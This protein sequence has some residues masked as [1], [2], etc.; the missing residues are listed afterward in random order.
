VKKATNIIEVYEVCKKTSPL[1]G[2]NQDY[3][4]YSYKKS[5][6]KLV[7]SFE[8]KTIKDLFI[9]GEG[10]SGKTSYQ[11]MIKFYLE[12]SSKIISID[13]GDYGD[14]YAESLAK[15]KDFDLSSILLLCIANKLLEIWP[16]KI[17]EKEVNPII[18]LKK[19]TYFQ[20]KL[21]N[22]IINDSNI[23]IF[24]DSI[25][26][27]INIKNDLSIL[28]KLVNLKMINANFIINLPLISKP[29]I[30]NTQFD[31]IELN[32]TKNDLEEIIYTRIDSNIIT[33]RALDLAI[34]YCNKNINKLIS[35][36]FEASIIALEN[37]TS[38]IE[39]YEVQRVINPLKEKIKKDNIQISKNKYINSIQIKDYFSI[40]NTKLENLEDK[41]EIYFVGENGDGKTIVLQ[42]LAL[43]FKNNSNLTILADKYIDNIKDDYVLNILEEDSYIN[44][45][46]FAYGINRNKIDADNKDKSGYSG[47]FDTPSLQN[48]TFLNRPQELFLLNN[49]ITD[50]FINKIENLLENKIQIA[51]I[52]SQIFFYESNKQIEF[53]MLSEGYKSTIIWLSDLVFRLIEKQPKITKL[54]DFKAVVLVDE[55]DL[56][57]HPKWKYSFVYKLRK[58]FPKIQF[59]MTTHSM[60]TILGASKDAVFYN[61]YKDKEGHTQLSEQFDDISDYS[62]NILITSRLFNMDS[63]KARSYDD[64]VNNLSEDDFKKHQLNKKIDKMLEEDDDIS[65]KEAILKQLEEYNERN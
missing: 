13:I 60:T 54:E 37:N 20:Y 52:A 27:F 61:I 16:N 58:I 57:L 62:A 40:K 30:N 28:N 56:Y 39:T 59:I 11:N 38:T 36:I 21:I 43:L 2:Y 42:A 44:D 32:L 34:R 53:K 23:F 12:K 65:A 8:K 9:L 49:S 33:Q 29:F 3:L 22:N 24:I 41:K 26:L 5:L 46:L 19:T 48:T 15:E 6:T 47:L 7:A 63:A 50:E 25:N 55:I 17:Y 1:N 18:F 4:L 10:S 35:T 31:I 64:K 51:N 14:Y 45:N